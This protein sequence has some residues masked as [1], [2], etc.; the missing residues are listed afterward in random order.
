MTWD[1]FHRRGEV[2]RTVLAHV[3]AHRDGR[4]P[5]GLPGVAQTFGDEAALLGALQLRW[6]T[7]LSGDVERELANSPADPEAAVLTAWRAAAHDLAGVRAVL[8]AAGEDPGS[9]EVAEMVAAARRKEWIL[10]AAMAGKASPSSPAAARV[11]RELEERARI[12]YRPSPPPP[13]T[14]GRHASDRDRRS[15][16]SRVKAAL[17]A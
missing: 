16:R 17:A 12:G 14:R 10:L 1:T 13:R 15:L 2:L 3:D 4:L 9:D 11:G 8:D 5:M 7:R 6:H